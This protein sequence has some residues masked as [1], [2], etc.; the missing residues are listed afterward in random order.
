MSQRRRWISGDFY[1]KRP[2]TGN[3]HNDSFNDNRFVTQLD[4][5]GETCLEVFMDSW[6]APPIGSSA[7]FRSFA[8]SLELLLEESDRIQRLRDWIHKELYPTNGDCCSFPGSDPHIKI[9][10]RFW[11]AFELICRAATSRQLLL[12]ESWCHCPPCPILP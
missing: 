6:L 12:N 1:W 5:S 2:A 3:H 11:R 4:K 10:A 9:V 8:K 7:V